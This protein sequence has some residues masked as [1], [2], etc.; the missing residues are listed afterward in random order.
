MTVAQGKILGGSSSVN[1]MIYIRGQQQD[2]DAWATDYGCTG[3]SYN[4]LLPWF[5]QAEGNESLADRYHGNAGPLSVSENRYRHPL[6]MA[7]IRAGQQSRVSCSVSTMALSNTSRP[8][9]K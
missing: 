5:I 6:S 3:W 7:F 4:D 1:G 2:Y 9:R 8:V